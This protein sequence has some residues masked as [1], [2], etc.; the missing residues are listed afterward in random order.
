[1]RTSRKNL[2]KNKRN[3]KRI[4]KYVIY[5]GV[6]LNVDTYLQ[7]VNITIDVQPTDTISTLKSRIIKQIFVEPARYYQLRHNGK[8]LQNRQTVADTGISEN[9]NLSF[10]KHM[11]GITMSKEERDAEIDKHKYGLCSECDNALD[12]RSDFVLSHQKDGNF[13][14]LCEACDEYYNM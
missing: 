1:M 9:D 10:Q 11:P 7:G 14:L 2:K 6:R 12:D 13:T 5:G 8:L 3:S 4:S